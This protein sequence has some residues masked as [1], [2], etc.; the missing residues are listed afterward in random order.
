M[1]W[2]STIPTALSTL[3]ALV[4]EA[5]VDTR[6]LARA[7]VG[8][9]ADRDLIV[10]GFQGPDIPAVEGRFMVAGSTVDPL[11]ERYVIHSRIAASRGSTEIVKVEQRAFYLLAV[12]GGVLA[13]NPTLSNTVMLASLGNFNHTPRQTGRGAL[14]IVQFDVEIEAFTTA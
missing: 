1:T 8:P 12:V 14:V 13:V 9:I 2:H 10:I 11:Q 5:A 7:N 4:Q 3:T 6:V